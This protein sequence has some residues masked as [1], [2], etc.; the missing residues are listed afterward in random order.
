MNVTMPR[1]AAE[2]DCYNLNGLYKGSV[3]CDILTGTFS[4]LGKCYN[5]HKHCE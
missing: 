1:S 2:N 3:D 4:N 5:T